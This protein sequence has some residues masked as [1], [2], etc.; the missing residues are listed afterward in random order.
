VSNSAP[1]IGGIALQ[2]SEVSAAQYLAARGRIVN[3]AGAATALHL[4]RLGQ[5]GEVQDRVQLDRVR[6]S[7]LDYAFST[8]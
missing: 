4:A 6:R 5:A 8:S 2:A 1:A 3:L 7:V